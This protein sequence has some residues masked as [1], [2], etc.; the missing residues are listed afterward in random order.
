[1]DLSNNRLIGTPPRFFSIIGSHDQHQEFVIEEAE[2]EGK[3]FQGRKI[4]ILVAVLGGDVFV[5]VCINR[6]SCCCSR[7]RSV[8]QTRLKVVTE[9]THTPVSPP[10]FLLVQVSNFDSNCRPPPGGNCL[11]GI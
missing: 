11:S 7:E 4:G 2:T 10:K 1:M 3:Q 8:P 6:C 9:I 5:L